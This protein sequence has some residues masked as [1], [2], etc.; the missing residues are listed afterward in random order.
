MT[1]QTA[2]RCPFCDAEYPLHPREIKARE[3]IELARI[4]AEE[5]ERVAQEKKRRRMEV[6]RARTYPELMKI[7][8]ERGYSQGWVYQML[9]ARR[10]R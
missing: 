4:T 10:K 9:K 3:D 8:K 7:A 1:F 2:P 5:A 6:G